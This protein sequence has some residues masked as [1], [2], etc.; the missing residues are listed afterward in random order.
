MF[1]F[2]GEFAFDIPHIKARGAFLRRGPMRIELFEIAESKPTPDERRR[3]NT[4]LQTQGTKHICFAVSDVQASLEK[5]HAAGAAIVGVARGVGKPVVEEADPRLH[6]GRAA[7]TA[8]F[9]SD[10][11]GALVEILGRGDFAP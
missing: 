10:P 2:E 6:E 1:G 4:D 8:F 9:I 3:P 7:A 5:L 11:W